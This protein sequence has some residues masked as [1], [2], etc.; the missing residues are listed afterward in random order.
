[1]TENLFEHLF[2]SFSWKPIPGC[3]G[4]FTLA[5]GRIHQGITE[6]F[7]LEGLSYGKSNQVR[8]P[9][10]FVS[11]DGAGMI[12][13]YSA[14]GWMHTLCTPE[15]YQRKMQSMSPIIELD[16]MEDLSF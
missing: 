16:A 5:E 9:F 2:H 8:D 3:P 1:M 7:A 11:V 12:S 10:A 4:R 14:E 6:R 15:G 13:Y